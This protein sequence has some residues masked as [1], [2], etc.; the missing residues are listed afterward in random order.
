MCS[1]LICCYLGINGATN[2]FTIHGTFCENIDENHFRHTLPTVYGMAGSPITTTIDGK[3][4]LIGAHSCA[5][6]DNNDINVGVSINSF[7][8]LCR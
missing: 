4:Y 7:L 2:N 6:G 8:K 1:F 5:Y 3:V